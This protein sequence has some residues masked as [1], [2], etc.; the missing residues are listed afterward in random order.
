MCVIIYLNKAFH[1]VPAVV[2]LNKGYNKNIKIVY[3][4][5][6]NFIKIG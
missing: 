6:Q 4:F 2:T 5:V 1:Q 3:F